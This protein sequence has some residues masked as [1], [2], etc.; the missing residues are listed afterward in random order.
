M[1]ICDAIEAV[2]KLARADMERRAWQGLPVP[3]SD[4]EACDALEEFAANHLG[5]Y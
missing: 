4:T 3:D 1:E 5:G 2:L